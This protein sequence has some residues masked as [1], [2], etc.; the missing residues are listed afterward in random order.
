MERPI[1]IEELCEELETTVE[2]ILRLA[3]TYYSGDEKIID[4]RIPI[5][6]EDRIRYGHLYET[7]PEIA[8]ALFRSKTR[9]SY[10]HVVQ[11]VK[12]GIF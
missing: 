3:K 4:G 10:T 7:H 5:G 8:N 11:H 2:H 9:G 1:A 12:R 6:I